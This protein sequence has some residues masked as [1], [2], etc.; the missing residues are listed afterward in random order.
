MENPRS[1][2][3]IS[4]VCTCQAHRP[5]FSRPGDYCPYCG[6]HLS[7]GHCPV[8]KGTGEGQCLTCHGLIHQGCA[9]CQGTGFIP[10]PIHHCSPGTTPGPNFPLWIP[11]SGDKIS[12]VAS[13]AKLED[14]V[15]Q[16]CSCCNG[17]GKVP[18]SLLGT[19]E[20]CPLCG[21]KGQTAPELPSQAGG[22]LWLVASLVLLGLMF[23]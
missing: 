15:R 7:F 5:S 10:V 18:G 13:I 19:A 12:P 21:G 8:C 9:T 23:G 22:W 1:T 17:T 4:K 14:S 6:K 11:G 3:E 16:V 2:Q 20:D